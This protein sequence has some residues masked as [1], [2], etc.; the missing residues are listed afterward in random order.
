MTPRVTLSVAVTLFESSLDL[1]EDPRI[2][3]LERELLADANGRIPP[4]LSI[5][6]V[7]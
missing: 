1:L 7:D 3:T 6:F 5:P 2:P 4:R